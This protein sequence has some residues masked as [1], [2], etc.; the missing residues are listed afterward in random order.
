MGQFTYYV[1][2]ILVTDVK[3]EAPLTNY[4]AQKMLNFLFI[5]KQISIIIN[6]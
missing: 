4:K 3:T 2:Q 5:L 1:S 6:N